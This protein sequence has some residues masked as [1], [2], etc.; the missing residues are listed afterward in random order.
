MSNVSQAGMTR[1][2]V[3]AEATTRPS[4]QRCGKPYLA[5]VVS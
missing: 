2:E 3:L 1:A 5:V 4:A